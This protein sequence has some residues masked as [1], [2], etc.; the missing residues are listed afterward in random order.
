MIQILNVDVPLLPILLLS[1]IAIG[2]YILVYLWIKPYLMVKGYDNQGFI[3]EFK[4][5]VSTLSLEAQSV[6][7]KN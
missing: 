6:Q 7:L 4:P 3:T 2:A 5:I 1:L